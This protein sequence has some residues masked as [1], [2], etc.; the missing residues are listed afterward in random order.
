[1]AD[2]RT[3]SAVTMINTAQRN[4]QKVGVV[5]ALT[6]VRAF[7]YVQKKPKLRKSAHPNPT[8]KFFNIERMLRPIDNDEGREEAGGA[9]NYDESED[10]DDVDLK[11]KGSA[12]PSSSAVLP[13]DED[14]EVDLCSDELAEILADGPVRQV[15]KSKVPERAAVAKDEVDGEDGGVFELNDWV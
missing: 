10:E 9:V 13:V 4:R 5:K 3:M 2:E 12:L 1:M 6:Q 14:D 7:Y 8:I 15:K 11:P